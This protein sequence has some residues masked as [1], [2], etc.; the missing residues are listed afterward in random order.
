MSV[1]KT[2][3]HFCGHNDR[4]FF[5]GCIRAHLNNCWKVR[6]CVSMPRLGAALTQ[7]SLECGHDTKLISYM[8]ECNQIFTWH[9]RYFVWFYVIILCL[10]FIDKI[11]RVFAYRLIYYVITRSGWQN[12]RILC[13][14]IYVAYISFY[15]SAFSR[16][17]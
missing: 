3:T 10:T 7:C 4:I 15:F 9:C 16:N 14:L 13:I 12:F 17:N 6:A 11:L 8:I 1:L 5:D 2:W